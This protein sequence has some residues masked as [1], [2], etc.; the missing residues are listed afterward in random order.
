MDKK[1]GV[2]MKPFENTAP[3][4]RLLRPKGVS[5]ASVAKK[6]KVHVQFVSNWERGTCLPPMPVMR[7][8]YNEMVPVDKAMFA[9][10]VKIDRHKQFMNKLLKGKK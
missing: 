10:C 1:Q 5:Q 7:K 6:Y 8:I 3:Q 2:I 9:I 4:L